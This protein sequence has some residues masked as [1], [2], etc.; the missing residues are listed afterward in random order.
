[1]ARKIYSGS[2]KPC[3]PCQRRWEQTMKKAARE[4][5]GQIRPRAIGKN[6]PADRGATGGQRAPRPGA[7]WGNTPHPQP[8]SA[9]MTYIAFLFGVAFV[10]VL[11]SFLIQQKGLPANH[12]G[13]KPKRQQRFVPGRQLQDNNRGAAG[14]F[15]AFRT[16][17]Y[18]SRLTWTRQAKLQPAGRD[19]HIA[20]GE[21]CTLNPM[22]SRAT[23]PSL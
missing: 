23:G 5:T 10:L 11:L 8:Q 1:M 2:M 20:P 4:K 16:R 9:L 22:Q 6:G 3:K 19:P 17:W 14:G 13:A 12:F 18:S 21:P 15:Q 7:T